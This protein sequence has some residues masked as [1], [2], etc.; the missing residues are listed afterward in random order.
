[1][2]FC[3]VQVPFLFLLYVGG[4][5]RQLGQIVFDVATFLLIILL[6]IAFVLKNTSSG[7]LCQQLKRHLK[8][9]RNTRH[10]RGEHH[11]VVS[12]KSML[13]ATL[14]KTS[15]IFG[16]TIGFKTCEFS[17]KKNLLEAAFRWNMAWETPS[18]S[19]PQSPSSNTSEKTSFTSSLR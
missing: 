15:V 8:K 16:F 7:R 4:C 19:F 9:L 6:M 10:T 12:H 14:T 3:G 18:D 17:F 5:E 1:M 13:N 2:A 11:A